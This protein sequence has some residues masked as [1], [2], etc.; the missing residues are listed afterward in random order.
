MLRVCSDFVVPRPLTSIEIGS[1][2]NKPITVTH[3]QS[4]F[5]RSRNSLSFHTQS[6]LTVASGSSQTYVRY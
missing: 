4:Y 1:V 5:A 3:C 2:A 6:S